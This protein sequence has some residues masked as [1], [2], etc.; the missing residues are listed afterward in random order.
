MRIQ[1]A[2]ITA[3]GPTQRS[4]P[5]QTLVDR[6]GE[7]KSALAI[8]LEEAQSAGVEDVCVIVHPGDEDSYAA[9][10][11]SSELRITYT[12]QNEKGELMASK[13]KIATWDRTRN[14]AKFP[15]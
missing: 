11:A 1:K 12:P 4:L 5:L 8:V 15:A 10:L 7:E 2:V 14:V 6:D 13:K 3:A 9:S